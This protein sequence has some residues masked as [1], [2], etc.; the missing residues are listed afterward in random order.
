MHGNS[1][2]TFFA[3]TQRILK[4]ILYLQDLESSIS[5][6]IDSEQYDMGA[7]YFNALVKMRYM[8]QL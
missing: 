6:D 7:S 5:Q 3:V 4:F 2:D 8:E 1:S